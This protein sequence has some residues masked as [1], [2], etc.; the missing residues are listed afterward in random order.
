MAE[1]TKK[2]WCK[3]WEEY[4]NTHTIELVL[5]SKEE[6]LEAMKAGEAL[7]NAD[8]RWGL[9]QYKWY[10]GKVIKADSYYDLY[11]EGKIV[12][13]LPQL[14]RRQTVPIENPESTGKK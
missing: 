14:Y 3:E 13:D 9:A 1:K 11:G 4:Q 8:E 6:A 12:T 7:V 2:Q 5:L 10:D